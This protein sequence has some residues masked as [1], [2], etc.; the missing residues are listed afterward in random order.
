MNPGSNKSI[1]HGDDSSSSRKSTGTED[2]LR[3]RKER[4]CLFALDNECP[5][6]MLPHMMGLSGLSIEKSRRRKL[7]EIK[8]AIS[9]VEK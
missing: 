5:N 7:Q 4:L 3:L 1:V 8:S 9:K 6:P 2:M